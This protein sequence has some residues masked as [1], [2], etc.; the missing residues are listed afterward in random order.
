M[1]EIDRRRFADRQIHLNRETE[2]SGAL[3]EPHR[4]R[5]MHLALQGEGGPAAVL[6]AGN[7]NDVDLGALVAR[8]GEVH[9]VDLDGDAVR[10]AIRRQPEAFRDRLVAHGDVDLSGILDVFAG[11]GARDPAP[12]EIDAAVTAAAIGAPLPVG[13]LG[14]CV[15]SCLLSQMIL[16]VAERLGERHPRAVDLVRALRTG[17]L[18]QLAL[19]LRPG[20]MGVIVSDMVSSD[21]APGLLDV[22]P[23]AL[24]ARMEALVREHNFFTGAN[25][26][27]LASALKTQ[28]ELAPLVD[29]VALCQPWLWRIAPR[30][31]YLVFAVRF[32]RAAVEAR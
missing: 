19:S 11:W 7:G 16:T 32:R 23:R 8:F 10:A 14:V 26:Y 5:V 20:G 12:A 1:R 9:L 13:D 29:G 22:A 24:G 17:H 28:P 21:T 3:F 2:G 30:R 31:G 6:G 27:V 25:P 4:R 18:R 15:S